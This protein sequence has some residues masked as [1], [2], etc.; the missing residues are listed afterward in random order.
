VWGLPVTVVNTRSKQ[1]VSGIAKVHWKPIAMKS[2]NHDPAAHTS[3]IWQEGDSQGL[4]AFLPFLFG[5]PAIKSSN[6]HANI[7]N[8]LKIAGDVFR[9][10]MQG[11]AV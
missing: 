6:E 9:G 8:N 4:P 2:G 5:G 3:F 1:G 10:P 7:Q 11:R